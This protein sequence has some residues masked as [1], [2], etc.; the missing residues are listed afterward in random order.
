[1]DGLSGYEY[2]PIIEAEIVSDAD[3]IDR[4]AAYRIHEMMS[5]T[6]QLEDKLQMKETLKKRIDQLKLYK[7]KQI[8]GTKSGNVRFDANLDLAIHYFS[9]FLNQLNET[10]EDFNFNLK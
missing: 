1:V 3:N 4:F 8:L 2:P 7:E 10:N 5:H 9:N 6:L